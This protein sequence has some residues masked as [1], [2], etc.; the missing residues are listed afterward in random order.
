MRRTAIVAAVGLGVATAAIGMMHTAG[1]R[2]VLAKLGVPCPVTQVDAQLV[3]AVR[4]KALVRARGERRAAERPALNLRLDVTTYA[5]LGAWAIRN[6]AP[7]DAITR[8]YRHLRCR[9]VSAASLGIGGPAISEIWFSFAPD[10]TLAA[11]NLYRRGMTE[12]E[13]QQSWQEATQR[14]RERL[15]TPTQSTGD[16]TLVGLATAPVAV[17]R[18]R[19]AYQDYI[20]LITAS[21]LPGSG[22]AVREQYMSAVTPFAGPAGKS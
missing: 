12:Q 9:G 17:A 19:Y 10:D 20:A 6:H 8:G 1:G 13:T 21:H 5:E 11:I 22:L 16:L 3:Q 18:V 4:G 2:Q 7:C 15:G 14:L